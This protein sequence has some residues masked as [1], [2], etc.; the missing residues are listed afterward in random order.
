MK[1][2]ADQLVT[3]GLRDA[4][5]EYVMLGDCWQAAERDAA[6]KLTGSASFPSGIPAL[7]DYVHSRGLTESARLDSAEDGLRFGRLDL[8]D[9]GRVGVD[10]VDLWSSNATKSTRSVPQVQCR[11]ESPAPPRLVCGLARWTDR[12][13]GA[14]QKARQEYD[15]AKANIH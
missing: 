1:A 13:L 10:C 15:T 11:A 5:Y 8:R 4:G 3:S 14:V 6:G 9:G 7:V 2:A 12:R